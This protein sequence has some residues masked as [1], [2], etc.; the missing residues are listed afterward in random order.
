MESWLHWLLAGAW[1][2]AILRIEKVAYDLKK[3]ELRQQFSY[4]DEGLNVRAVSI[5]TEDSHCDHIYFPVSDGEG[6]YTGQ[7]C[8]ICGKFNSS[9]SVLRPKIDHPGVDR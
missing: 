1:I 4:G 7:Q 5:A 3:L 9:E 6:G 8:S 2:Y